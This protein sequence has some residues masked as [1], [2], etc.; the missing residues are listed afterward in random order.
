MTFIVHQKV[1]SDFLLPAEV[2]GHVYKEKKITFFFVCV[3]LLC[4]QELS[5][6]PWVDA[7]GKGRCSEQQPIQ[8]NWQDPGRSAE[9]HCFKMEKGRH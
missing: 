6:G 1:K 2:P 8:S 7:G 4:E 3:C 9:R 5:L